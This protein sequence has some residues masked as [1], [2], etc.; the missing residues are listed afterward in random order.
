MAGRKFRT[1]DSKSIQLLPQHLELEK[2]AYESLQKWELTPK[3]RFAWEDSK[4]VLGRCHY[5]QKVITLSR[6]YCLFL[7]DEENK[8]T[9]LHEIAH[10]LTREQLWEDIKKVPVNTNFKQMQNAYLGHGLIW[11]LFCKKV[12]AKP[13]ACYDGAIQIPKPR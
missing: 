5:D 11:E 13:A 12:G 6:Y 1:S 7:P 8:D 10:A 3:W 2:M 9:I 4:T